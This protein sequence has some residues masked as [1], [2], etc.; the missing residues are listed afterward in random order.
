MLEVVD[1]KSFPDPIPVYPLGDRYFKLSE[2]S[3]IDIYTKNDGVFKFTFYPG[4]V[5]NFRSGGR[6]IDCFI[7]Q[8]GNNDQQRSY[9]P[10]DAVYTP[11]DNCNGEHPLSRKFGDE[12]LRACLIYSKMNKAKANAVYLS[13]RAF[14]GRAY[15]DDD[16]FTRE[17][18]KLFKFEWSAK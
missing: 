17:N 14:G 11:C 8:F 10:H 9:L 2:L 7:D 1:I 6:L 15:S 13:V 5:T 12:L 16:Q 3:R 4:F 18:R